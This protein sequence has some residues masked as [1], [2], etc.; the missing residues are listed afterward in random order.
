[1]STVQLSN[2]RHETTGSTLFHCMINLALHPAWQ[3]IVQADIEAIFGHQEPS[4]W[5]YRHGLEKLTMSSLDAVVSES[6]A[7][8]FESTLISR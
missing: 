8:S 2:R 3:R 5:D 4:Q 1:M 6:K 7:P